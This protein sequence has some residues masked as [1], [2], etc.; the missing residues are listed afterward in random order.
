MRATGRV[1][2]DVLHT[3]YG[4]LVGAVVHLTGKL[5]LTAHELLVGEVLH[6]GAGD[7][8]HTGDWAHTVDYIK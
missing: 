8:L 7:Q 4:L 5:L 1:A 2:G 6:Q 3:G